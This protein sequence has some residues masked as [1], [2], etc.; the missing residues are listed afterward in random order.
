MLIV[1]DII[2]IAKVSHLRNLAVAKDDDAI[3]KFIHLGISELF[4][5]FNLSIK[6][7]AINTNTELALYEIRN[8][9]I[10]MLLSIYN[11]DGQELKQTDVL[12]GDYDYKLINY[13]SFLLRKPKNDLLFAVYKASPKRVTDLEDKVDLPEAMTDALLI[14]IAYMGHSSINKDNVNEASAYLKRFDQ[15]C[16]ELDMQG[17]KISLNTEFI[18]L[19]ARGFV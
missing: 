11:S 14:Y 10:N 1:K 8:E 6:V 13:R 7:E 18:D 4:N 12:G 16:H 5:R 9:D 19:K 17:Y 3:I 2:D 15:A